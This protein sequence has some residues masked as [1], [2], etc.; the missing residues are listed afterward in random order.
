MNSKK[1][2]SAKDARLFDLFTSEA[3]LTTLKSST[4]N[5]TTVIKWRG[6]V[7]HT[8]SFQKVYD[9]IKTELKR[10]ED[11]TKN[12]LLKRRGESESTKKSLNP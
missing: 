8:K 6:R 3:K 1:T 5:T 11:E 10:E 9:S 12:P 4:G 2:R 7:F